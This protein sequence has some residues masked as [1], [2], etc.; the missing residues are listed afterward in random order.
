MRRPGPDGR[1]EGREFEPD[2]RHD[3]DADAASA[4]VAA[5][6]AQ[7]EAA[8]AQIIG[9]NHQVMAGFR[10]LE[11]QL[12]ERAREDSR[13]IAALSKIVVAPADLTSAAYH[14]AAAGVQQQHSETIRRVSETI[15]Q[16]E[17]VANRLVEN[18][19]QERGERRLWITATM[20]AAIGAAS[21]ILLGVIGGYYVGTDAGTARGYAA[22]RDEVAAASWANTTNGRFA[23][24]LDRD[25]A[26]QLMRTCAGQNWRQTRQD[27]RRVCFAGDKAGTQG[28]YLP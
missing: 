8:L 13:H 19:E 18:A 3:F 12:A 20:Y 22:A 28:W 10:R 1:E 27:G 23:R 15:K 17:A 7:L 9:G 16:V 26:L 11:A 14:G 5:N 24:K 2:L 4:E 21:A 6:A 25:G